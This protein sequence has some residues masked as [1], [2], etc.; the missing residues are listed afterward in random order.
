MTQPQNGQ[1]RA[2]PTPRTSERVQGRVLGKTAA[3][4]P[5]VPPSL[6]NGNRPRPV[7]TP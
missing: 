7:R 6:A 5:P 3:P 2:Q 4:R 1:R